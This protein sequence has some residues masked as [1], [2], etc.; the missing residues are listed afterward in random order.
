MADELYIFPDRAAFRSW[1][2]EN[3]A[4]EGVWLIFGK[5]GGPKTLTAAQA[6]E[7]ALCFGWIDGQMESLGEDRYRK[8]F[9]PRRPQSKWSEKNRKLAETLEAE[10]MMTDHGRRAIDAA[11]KHGTYEG[12]PRAA[13]TD[14]QIE[15]LKDV[16]RPYAKALA[17]FE[18]MTPS[19]RRAYTG[20]YF[21]TKTEEG[22]RKQLE[23]LVERLNLGLNPMESLAKKKAEMGAE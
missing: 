22:R 23:R 14:E 16:L 8:Y 12:A 17:S 11:K 5:K 6:L 9:A 1:L 20:S 15:A 10:G 3:V 7:E 18:A 13:I 4:Q 2:E 19:H 21:A